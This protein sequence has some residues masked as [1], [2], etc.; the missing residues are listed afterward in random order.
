[1]LTFLCAG[2][3]SVVTKIVDDNENNLC[4]VGWFNFVAE[5]RQLEQRVSRKWCKILLCPRPG[6]H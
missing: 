6:G 1:M 5:R 2:D 3:M 4:R